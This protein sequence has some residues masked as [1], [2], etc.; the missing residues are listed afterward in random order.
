LRADV[1]AVVRDWLTAQTPLADDPVF[2]SLRGGF[3]SADALQRCVNLHAQ[4]ASTTCTSLAGRRITPHTLRHTAA[5]AL[6][7]N[8]VDLHIIALWLGP[9]SIETTQQY[10]NADTSRPQRV[11]MTQRT[12]PLR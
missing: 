9:E 11:A 8:G 7:Q 1:V 3:L 5:M 12:F 10:L 4:V 6:F 2:P